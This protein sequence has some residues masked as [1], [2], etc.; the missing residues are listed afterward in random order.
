MLYRRTKISGASY[1]FT[2]NCADRKGK[3]LIERI[4]ELRAA[5]SVVQSKH[6]F[7][8]DAIV[9]LPDHLHMVMTLPPGDTNYPLRWNLIKGNF[10]RAIEHS[11]TISKARMHKRERGIWQRRFWEHLIRDEHDYEQHINYIH[12]NPVKHGYVGDPVDWRFSSIHRY[13]ARG[14]ISPGWTVG[15]ESLDGDFGE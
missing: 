2:I 14:V 7:K 4:K 15:V 1:F 6:S 12:Y 3:L 9:I 10:S 11:E 13:I 8:T 5:F